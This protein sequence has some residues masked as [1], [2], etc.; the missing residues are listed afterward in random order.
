M[1][2]II[3]TDFIASDHGGI[4]GNRHSAHAAI[5]D[6]AGNLLHAVDDPYRMTFAR[7]TAKPAQTLALLETGA[8]ERFPTR[9][10]QMHVKRVVDSVCGHGGNES[11]WGLDGCKLLAPAFELH[12]LARMNARSS[13]L[14]LITRS[15]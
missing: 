1:Q 12:Y 3:P 7:S 13:L 10:V 15:A 4:V 2:L 8:V 9:P 14:R 5:T 6:A 11:D